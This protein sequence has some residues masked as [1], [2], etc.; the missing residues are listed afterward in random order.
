VGVYQYVLVKLACTLVTVAT[1][2]TD[3]FGFGEFRNWSAAYVYVTIAVNLSQAVAMYCLVFFTHAL[4]REYAGRSPPLRPVL[5]LLC[6]KGVV[7]LMFWQGLVLSGMGAAGVLKP[8]LSY[9]QEEVSDGLQNFVVC[10]EMFLFAV[11]HKWAFSYH[12]FVHVAADGV[13]TVA[14]AGTGS[15]LPL[16]AELDG[17]AARASGAYGALAADTSVVPAAPAAGGVPLRVHIT[18]VQ[19][20]T[21]AA[22]ATPS[23]VQAALHGMLPTDLVTDAVR[24]FRRR[25]SGQLD[26]EARLTSGPVAAAPAPPPP[27]PPSRP[28]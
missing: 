19:S 28:A 16:G 11:A 14:A 15:G 26:E 1:M 27:P 21:P 13:V 8:T 4:L 9:T 3:T 2:A 6:I 5:K 22:V 23:L 17:P 24:V 10:I 7:F 20:G 18:H 25:N 12:D